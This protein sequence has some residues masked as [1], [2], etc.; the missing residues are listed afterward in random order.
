ML[1]YLM[2]EANIRRFERLLETNVDADQRRIISALLALEE[3]KLVDNRAANPG[4][5]W[6]RA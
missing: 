4:A 2:A 3:L 5:P 6:L 1:K